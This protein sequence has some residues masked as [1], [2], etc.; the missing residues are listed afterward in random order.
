MA[1]TCFGSS[2]FSA[3]SSSP[4][5]AKITAAAR[6]ERSSR[7]YAFSRSA[8]ARAAGDDQVA[9]RRRGVLHAADHLGE[10]RVGDVV[11]DDADHRHVALQ[12]AAGE[13]IGHVIQR[14]CRVQDALPGGGADR[15]VGVGDDA[16]DGGRGDAA[17]RATSVM[18]VTLAAAQ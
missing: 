4:L 16:R 7:T 14:P 11:D 13:G 2:S 12:Q 15:V 9:A 5:P 18:D 1:A 17:S 6:I 3:G 10:V 8:F